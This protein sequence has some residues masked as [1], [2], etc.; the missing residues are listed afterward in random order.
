M[1]KTN[2]FYITESGKL[3]REI[4]P[5][6]NKGYMQFHLQINKTRLHYYL[7]RFV[8]EAFRGEIPNGFEINHVDGNKGNNSLSNLELVSKAGNMKHA[9]LTGLIQ[10]KKLSDA[11]VRAI[12]LDSRTSTSIAQSYNVVQSTVSR[13][14]SGVRRYHVS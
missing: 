5:A 14:K 10:P 4:L 11:D 1:Q 3:L 7:H 9:V 2:N 13:I 8:W 12:R 6:N